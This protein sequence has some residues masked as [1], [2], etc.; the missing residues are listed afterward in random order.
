MKQL[1]SSEHYLGYKAGYVSEDNTS[2]LIVSVQLNGTTFLIFTTK[3]THTKPDHTKRP[4]AQRGFVQRGLTLLNKSYG[5]KKLLS[6]ENFKYARMK[7]GDCSLNRRGSWQHQLNK[8]CVNIYS[9]KTGNVRGLSG[10]TRCFHIISQKTRLS[11]K[12]YGTK[13]VI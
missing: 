10:S 12:C 11:E 3:H 5:E 2:G 13:C 9:D 6:A 8:H 4:L 7:V 1:S